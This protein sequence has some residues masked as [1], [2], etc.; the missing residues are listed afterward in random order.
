MKRHGLCTLLA[1]LVLL[2]LPLTAHAKETQPERFVITLAGDCT[3]GANQD[4]TYA[5][6]GFPKVVGA[7]YGYPFRNVADYFAE[8]DL[9]LV[10][11]EGPLCDGGASAQKSFVFRG[12]PA[13]TAILTQGSVEAVSLANNHTL[14][15]G[16][17]GYEST[18]QALQ[19]A[20][21]SYAESGKSTL[22]TTDSGFTVGLYGSVFGSPSIEQMSKDIAQLRKDGAQLVI[23][24]AHWGVEYTYRP[25]G[26]QQELGRAAI[27]AGADIVYG[28]HPHV[29]QPIEEYGDGVIFYSLGNFSFGGNTA[30]RDFDTVLIQQEILRSPDG[31]VALGERT[32]IPACISSD[33]S[34]NNY[35]PTPY[36]PDSEQSRRVL[37][38]LDGTWKR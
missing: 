22:L 17:A 18:C 9:T 15:Y 5:L 24:C 38:K 35:Q 27:D 31:T 37:A 23:V 32:L 16:A 6:C 10:N 19:D 30:P 14:D 8:D 21:L 7:D 11:L 29:L 25:N 3:L 28:T 36:A 26:Q 1:A 34:L 2:G 13:Y 20:G 12:P 33:P 4:N